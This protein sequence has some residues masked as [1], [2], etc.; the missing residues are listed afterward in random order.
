MLVTTLAGTNP[1]DFSIVEGSNTCGAPLPASGT[2]SVVLTFRPTVAGSRSAVLN[3]ASTSGG[4]G[5]LLLTGD[6]TALLQIK[7]GMNV[8]SHP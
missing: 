5:S 1:G 4:A 2:C 8:V 6:A 3:I 7:E